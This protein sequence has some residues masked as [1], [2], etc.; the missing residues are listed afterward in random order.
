MLNQSN[1]W[2]ARGSDHSTSVKIAT[3]RGPAKVQHH[4]LEG[5]QQRPPRIKRKHRKAAFSGCPPENG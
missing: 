3:F 1:I 5:L 2:T 4:Q